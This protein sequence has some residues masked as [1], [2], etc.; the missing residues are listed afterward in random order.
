MNQQ[1][2]PRTTL[3]GI[4]TA[5]AEFPAAQAE[6]T[7]FFGQVAQAVT[8]ERE[9]DKFGRYVE[10]I[11]K[12]CG[13]E[14]RYSAIPDYGRPAPEVFEFY[15]KNWQLEPFPTT[16]DRM[17]VYERASV[18]LATRAGRQALR[19]AGLDPGAVTHLVLTS[20]TG[21]FAP[22]PDVLLLEALGLPATT[23]RTIVG[24]MG[25]YAQFAALKLVDQIVRADPD[26]VVLSIAVELCSLHYQRT[27][28]I[29]TLISNCLFGDGAAATV[30]ARAGRFS[31]PKADV[32]A[33]HSAISPDTTRNMSWRIGDQGFVMT[34]DSQVPVIVEREAPR[35]V[36][37]LLRRGD[38]RPEDVA[39]WAVHPG[40]TKI[41]G[42]VQSA[43]GLEAAAVA[44]AHDV[45]RRFGNMSSATI[46]FVLEA[47]LARR[48]GQ[49]GDPGQ[50]QRGAARA[51]AGRGGAG[52]S[53]DP[54]VALGFGPGL[55]M[56]G[57]VLRCA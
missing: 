47:E 39:R 56:E 35:F 19:D 9:R 54:L 11:G 15:P 27:P 31:K 25:C 50:G 17:R 34:L 3:Y 13:V 23:Q 43:L 26:A 24:F 12:G 30:F 48:A 32:L 20:C 14:M 46:I 16:R 41:V 10:R 45:L 7:R 28:T 18:P 49:P 5:T 1:S 37:S 6:V 22:G 44:S 53:G 4:A 29:E 51:A 36:E 52:R 55:T 21:F 8:P 42:A 40:G 2:P 38:T 57:A 33:T